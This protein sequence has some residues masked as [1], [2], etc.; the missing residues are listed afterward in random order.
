[1]VKSVRTFFKIRMLRVSLGP[2][3]KILATR[4]CQHFLLQTHFN[5][6]T[7]QSPWINIPG[8]KYKRAHVFLILIE[9]QKNIK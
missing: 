3:C 7:Q 2:V 5:N 9:I 6:I 1:M 8:I 4:V